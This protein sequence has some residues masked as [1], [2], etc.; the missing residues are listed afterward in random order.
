MHPFAVISLLLQFSFI[1]SEFHDKKPHDSRIVAGS[2]AIDSQFPWQAFLISCNEKYNC[3]RCGGSLIS[4]KHILT[5]A[6]CVDA[7]SMFDV[8][9]GSI[10]FYNPVVKIKSKEKIQHAKYNL[11]TLENDIAI[12]KLPTEVQLS[13]TIQVINLPEFNIGSLEAETVT[14]SGF[15]KINGKLLFTRLS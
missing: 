1:L 4:K 3:G 2:P 8:A 13:K 11:E 9:L 5:A 12:V 15:G 7:K 14:V 6:H 10:K